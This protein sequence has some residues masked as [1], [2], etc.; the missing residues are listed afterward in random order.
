MFRVQSCRGQGYDG[1]AA[2]ADKVNDF[3]NLFLK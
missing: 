2:V 3:V 1:V